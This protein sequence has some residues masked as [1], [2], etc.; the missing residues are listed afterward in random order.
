[1]MLTL[2]NYQTASTFTPKGG[3]YT[4]Y[5]LKNRLAGFPAG[6]CWSGLVTPGLSSDRPRRLPF[7]HQGSA[8]SREHG[9]AGMPSVSLKTRWPECHVQVPSVGIHYCKRC[10]AA[11]ASEYSPGGR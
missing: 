3:A 4:V 6:G 11:L 2:W 10:S 7:A 5:E 9:H 1:M 8:D